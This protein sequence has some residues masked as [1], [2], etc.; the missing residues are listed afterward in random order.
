MEFRELEDSALDAIVRAT[1]GGEPAELASSYIST[2]QTDRLS[3]YGSSVPLI[4]A[5][6][7][8]L[9]PSGLISSVDAQQQKH[10][11]DL[12]TS[13]I[14][15]AELGIGDLPPGYAEDELSRV[16]ISDAI[17]SLT[18]LLSLVFRPD[19][20]RKELDLMIVTRLLKPGVREKAVELI[21]NQ[22]RV[23]LVPQIVLYTLKM[24]LRTCPERVAA[25][26][27]PGNIFAALMANSATLGSEYT[28]EFRKSASSATDG[29]V[30][31]L[32]VRM[33]SGSIDDA[34]NLAM[35]LVAN[36]Y[37]NAA[38]DVSGLLARY[39]RRWIEMSKEDANLGLGFDLVVEYE[40]W[41]GIPFLDLVTVMAGL[42]GLSV[43]STPPFNVNNFSDSL[44]WGVTRLEQVLK[45]IARTPGEFV[46]ALDVEDAEFGDSWSFSTFERFPVLRIAPDLMAVVSPM[47]ALRR[48]YGWLPLFDMKEGMSLVASK[49][50]GKESRETYKIASQMEAYFRSN[51]ERY[52]L[53]SLGS[54]V[55]VR[56]PLKRLWNGDELRAAFG[57]KSKLKLADAAVEDPDGWIVFEVSSRHLKRE[58]V[59]AVSPEDLAKD[60]L[61]GVVEKAR[62]LESTLNQIKLDESKLTGFPAQSRRRYVPVLVI[63]EGFPVNPVMREMI[64]HKL[65]EAGVLQSPEFRPL[66]VMD[67]EEIEL[68]EA[69]IERGNGS[70][71]GLLQRHE[72]STLA[73]SSFRD[74]LIREVNSRSRPT[75][76]ATSWSTAL[77]PLTK[78]LKRAMKR[79]G[80]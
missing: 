74:F 60:I 24:A 34:A 13:Y 51:V 17:C 47:F 48:A 27:S 35:E 21:E 6:H 32:G 63:S 30:V 72:R 9:L 53:E 5:M 79:A 40:K 50:S 14:V 65:R 67:V 77:E 8:V 58:V 26:V 18:Y 1:T 22:D 69:T 23:F 12:A 59:A 31:D 41:V 49:Q 11:F 76:I 46:E 57:S 39:Q 19:T 37:F 66:H 10:P 61:L 42:W 71:L 45:I 54:M 28:N 38:T 73:G 4:G 25:G 7:T 43:T 44:G 64:S 78:A 20:K 62:Q 75:R 36:Q 56:S 52:I 2:I 80:D 70:I 16:S 15:P 33:T 55:P 3:A 68:L 29:K